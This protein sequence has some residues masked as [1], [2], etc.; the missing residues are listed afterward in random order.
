MVGELWTVAFMGFALTSLNLSLL[1]AKCSPNSDRSQKEEGQRYP[2]SCRDE[3]SLGSSFPHVPTR[4]YLLLPLDLLGS[5]GP[6]PLSPV[7]H[8]L[9]EGV[10]VASC[11]KTA[12]GLST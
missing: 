6:N 5:V 9:E 10:G 11:E 3:G 1:E 12:V 8:S 4:F 2:I 7:L